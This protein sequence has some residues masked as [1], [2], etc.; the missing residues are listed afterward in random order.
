[1]S[2]LETQQIH[3]DPHFYMET[4]RKK[5][6]IKFGLYKYLEIMVGGSHDKE[7]NIQI[8]LADIFLVVWGHNPKTLE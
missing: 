7:N 8:K 4:P 5:I 2:G 3:Y 6:Y 1:M